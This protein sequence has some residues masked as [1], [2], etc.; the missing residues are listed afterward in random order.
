MVQDSKSQAMIM[1]SCSPNKEDGLT[2]IT[3]IIMQM[4]ILQSPTKANNHPLSQDLL[5]NLRVTIKADNLMKI[6]TK[7]LSINTNTITMMIMKITITMLNN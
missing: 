6:S 4:E 1:C 2:K 7:I 3:I 5:N